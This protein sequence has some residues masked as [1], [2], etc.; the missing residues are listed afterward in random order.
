MSRDIR[1]LLQDAEP[2]EVLPPDLDRIDRRVRRRQAGRFA[3][4]AAA[5]VV[6]VAA[7]SLA[8]P[9]LGGPDAPVIQPDPAGSETSAPRDA[10]PTPTPTPDDVA[11]APA[12]DTVDLRD[13][14]PMGDAGVAVDTAGGVAFVTLEGR[15]AGVLAGHRLVRSGDPT[16]GA[17]A[18]LVEPVDGGTRVW[19]DPA[20]GETVEGVVPVGYSSALVPADDDA[21][22]W[23]MAGTGEDG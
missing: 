9:D 7:G 5:L 4:G 22:R 17:G 19:V 15:V 11:P 23:V 1:D 8:L 12:A 18:V 16:V 6:V 10:A 13:L 14:P 2:R 20:R 3:G 21:T